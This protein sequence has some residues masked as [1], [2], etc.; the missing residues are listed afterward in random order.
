MSRSSA[1]FP[2]ARRIADWAITR[3]NMAVVLQTLG[4][5]ESAPQSLTKPRQIFRDSLEVFAARQ[6]RSQLGGR[7]EQHRQRAAGARPARD[8]VEARSKRRS[9][10]SARRSKARPRKRC[11]STGRRRQNNI[12][13]ALFSLSEREAGRAAPDRGR[14][15]LPRCP[16]G[17][18]ARQGAVQWAMVQNN[19]GNTLNTLGNYHNDTSRYEAAAQPSARRWR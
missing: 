14:G 2:T 10:P 17:I 5:R 19:L 13:I 8:G 9:P 16:R 4:E 18:H 6:G 12:G 11:R 7:A 3:N 1:S 15:R